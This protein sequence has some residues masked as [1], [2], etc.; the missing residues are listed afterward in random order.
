MPKIAY[1]KQQ[2]EQIREKLI[3]LAQ[4]LM[5]IQGVR[6]TTIEQIYQ[7][8]GISRTFFYTFFASKED[9]ILE[10][11]YYQQPLLLA[12]AEKLVQNPSLSWE[13]ALKRFL[14]TCCHGERN[15]IVLLTIT[16][17]QML[18]Q[19]LS[20][21]SYQQF[22]RK[23]ELLFGGILERFG[24]DPSIRRIHLF[25]NLCLSVLLIHQAIP[26][27]LPLLIPEMAEETTAIQI[28]SIVECLKQMYTDTQQSKQEASLSSDAACEVIDPMK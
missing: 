18:F 3:V 24:I 1:S 10:I 15:R 11:I 26:D 13:E 9:L 22:R 17:Q 27:T 21:A 20:P 28:C 2:R 8:A 12:Y 7:R 19:R 5:S 14:Y 23:Q 4:E 16:E 25:T 6:H